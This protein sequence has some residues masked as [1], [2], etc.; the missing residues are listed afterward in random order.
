MIDYIVNFS[1][2]DVNFIHIDTDFYN[3]TNIY[4]VDAIIASNI[5]S[6]IQST[7]KDNYVIHLSKPIIHH[8][9]MSYLLFCITQVFIPYDTNK[10][11]IITHTGKENENIKND[12]LL[13][14]K[15]LEARTMAMLPPNIGTP[16]KMASEVEHIFRNISDVKVKV[17]DE[18]QMKKQGM[19]LILAVGDGSKNKPRLVIVERKV[20]K[21]TK[22]I[23]M[24]GK[25]IT[26]DSGGLA[27]KSFRYMKDMKFDKIGAVYSIYAL[28]E[29]LTC[30]ETDN[31]NIIGIFPFA[32]NLIS[33]KAVVPSSIIKSY[34]GKTVE[35]VNPDAEGRLILA[36]ALSYS[37]KYKPDMVIDMATL[38]GN[39]ETV[40]CFQT[41]YFYCNNESLKHKIEEIGE[42][43]GERMNPMP[44]WNEYSYLL[45]SNVADLRNDVN[46]NNCD[47]FMAALF[48]NEFIP[49]DC[50]WI[51]FDLTTKINNGI[52]DGKG[53]R[54]LIEIVKA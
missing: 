17:L 19:N 21:P 39:A 29:L 25:G 4:K 49:K 20:K 16:E 13:M 2:D 46:G 27:I 1:K 52:P 31:K 22:T 40:N 11:V 8:K 9:M 5:G 12:I 53:I 41:A 23:C 3:L 15:V 42:K 7:Q 14:N 38:T 32:D 35:V 18:K 48:L 24:L 54:S 44:I 28:H 10:Q 45:K 51:H 50:N 43:L 37:A 36:D 26:F 6:I 33:E 34:C 30:K 47:A